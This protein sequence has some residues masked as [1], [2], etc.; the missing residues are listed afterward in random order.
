MFIQR[1]N[2]VNFG[3]ARQK[4]V[5]FTREEAMSILKSEPHLKKLGQSLYAELRTGKL[6]AD[7]SV[8]QTIQPKIVKIKRSSVPLKHN[9]HPELPCTI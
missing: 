1:I 4:A 9:S 7:K 6:D 8:M 2:P 3:S 5:E